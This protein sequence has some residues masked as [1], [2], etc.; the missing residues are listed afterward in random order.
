MDINLRPNARTFFRFAIPSVASM[1]V[2]SLYT[3][4]D[5]IFLAHAVG[6]YALAA[7][8]LVLPYINAVFAL[9]VFFSMGTS[10]VIA[11]ALGRGDGDE[12]NR[13]FTQ[14]TYVLFVLSLMLAVLVEVFTEP[15]ARFL[16]ASGNTIAYVVT[17][18][19]I[20]APFTFFFMVGYSL[21]VL[22]KTGGHPS[23]SIVSTLSCFTVNIAL[24]LVLV[25]WL[26]FGIAG[27]AVATVTA[28]GVG[29]AI[30]LVHFL[31]KKSN[32]RF[33]RLKKLFLGVYGKILSLGLSEFSGEISLALVVFLFNRAAFRLLGDEGVVSYAVLAYVHNIVVMVM[34]GVA[35]GMQPL[36]GLSHGARDAG[37][38]VRYYGYALKTAAAA[39][40]VCFLVCQLFSE[41]ITAL[42]LERTSAMFAYTAKALRLFSYSFLFVG[43]NLCSA[44]FFNA[45]ERPG[46]ALVISVGR[47][48]VA[49]TASM[50]LMSALFGARGL[51]LATPVSEAIVLA[52]NIALVFT[53][54]FR[55]SAL[56]QTKNA[57]ASQAKA[58]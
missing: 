50:Y 15:L 52:V 41:G 53:L 13:I 12:A 6:E 40:V 23:V 20:V 46:R 38:C 7:I 54:F 3:I 33:V 51:W 10:T 4:M 57:P 22:V 58:E 17:Y 48:I 44:G 55:N 28:Q 21:E 35:Q 9:A 30:F 42:L 11:F 2:Y 19:R 16:G 27:G 25:V 36:V 29:L 26:G 14:N 34:A 31:C 1:L 32:L 49:I 39:A 5:G 24:H 37:G 43:F 45:M 8:N 56:R 18:L 47:G